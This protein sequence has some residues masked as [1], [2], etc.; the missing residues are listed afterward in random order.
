METGRYS[1]R[2]YMAF[3]VLGMVLTAGLILG[4]PK[5]KKLSFDSLQQDY[6]KGGWIYERLTTDRRPIDIA[7][8]G[9][10]HTEGNVHDELIQEELTEKLKKTVYIANLAIPQHGRN[11]HYVI[12]KELFKYKNPEYLVLEVKAY[13]SRKSHHLFNRLADIEDI[14]IPSFAI[15]VFAFR[16]IFSAM[17]WQLDQYLMPISMTKVEYERF[18]FRNNDPGIELKEADL[19]KLVEKRNKIVDE[20]YLG[21]RFN[22]IEFSLPRSYHR[23]IAALARKHGTKLIYLYL[24]YYNAPSMPREV[25]YYRQFGD[26]WI[27]PSSILTNAGYW[28]D[29]G[30]LNTEGALALA[31]WLASRILRELKK[32]R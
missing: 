4:V 26:V 22:E 25:E 16:D 19:R 18:G 6:I 2:N 14:I 12:A 29:A 5:N 24:P 1:V 27:P 13:E 30:H 31:P 17:R 8:I 15:N 32:S 21:G 11:M 28:K 3:L 23:K 9:T 10:S 7:F 20:S